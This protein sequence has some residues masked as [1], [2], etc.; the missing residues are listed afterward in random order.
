MLVVRLSYP[1]TEIGTRLILI[2][3][4]MLRS[5]C[6]FWKEVVLTKYLSSCEEGTRRLM[7][8]VSEIL[9]L[10]WV[11]LGHYLVN[12]DNGGAHQGPD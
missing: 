7:C 2:S 8:V 9:T 1:S 3:G 10:A 12:L 6:T 4:L 11:S 5:V